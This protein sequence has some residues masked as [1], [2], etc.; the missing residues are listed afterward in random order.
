MPNSSL[1]TICTFNEAKNLVDLVNEILAVAPEVDILVIDDNSPDGTGEIADELGEKDSRVH[2]LHRPSKLGLGTA[3]MAG[4]KYAID[5]GYQKMLNLDADFSHHPRHLR[6][7]LDGVPEV[8]VMIGSRYVEGGGVVG[9]GLKRHLMS[10]SINMSARLLLGLKTRDNSG[11]YRCYNVDKLRRIDFDRVRARGYAIQEEILYRIRVVEGSFGETPIIFEDRRLGVSKINRRE[12]L[13]AIWILW[14]L[15]F[16]R[17][18]GVPVERS[19]SPESI[20]E[21]GRG[22]EASN[23]MEAGD[24]QHD[25]PA[26]R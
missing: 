22:A 1:V 11:S 10:Q 19:A 26:V 13:A 4:M 6:S 5:N 17:L 7:I 24:S 9:W 25:E 12:I 14:A 21:P 20:D 3:L 16:E 15:F 23:V 8:D 2:C 18:R